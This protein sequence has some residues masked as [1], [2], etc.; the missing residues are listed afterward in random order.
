M[1]KLRWFCV[2]QY[3]CGT[4]DTN[5]ND[6]GKHKCLKAPLSSQLPNAMMHHVKLSPQLGTINRKIKES[7]I[8]TVP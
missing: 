2:V 4:L 3:L 1:H 6:F 7:S 8:N 5:Y